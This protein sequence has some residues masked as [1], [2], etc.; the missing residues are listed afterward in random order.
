MLIPS[1]NLNLASHRA[2]KFRIIPDDVLIDAVGEGF[3][4][5]GW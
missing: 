1:E 5:G 3:V 4:V 2:E